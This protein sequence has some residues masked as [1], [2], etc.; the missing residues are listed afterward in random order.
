MSVSIPHHMFITKV[1]IAMS[2]V[3][4][5]DLNKKERQ[6]WNS[7]P[8]PDDEDMEELLFWGPEAGKEGFVR[9]LKDTV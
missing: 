9:A 1:R 7:L 8:Y 2:S 6:V 4:E 5:D 3:V